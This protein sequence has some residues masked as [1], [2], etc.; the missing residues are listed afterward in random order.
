M[1]WDLYRKKIQYKEILVIIFAV[2]MAVSGVIF[3][4]LV[5]RGCIFLE[6]ND[7]NE[8]S[9]VLL[10]IQA[11]ITTLTLTIIALLSGNISDFYMGI[12][13]SA[14]FLEIRPVF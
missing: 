1:D 14:Y 7:L 9:L 2:L 5:A 3:D 8:V 11:T 10:Q 4:F 6:V 12:S 13:I